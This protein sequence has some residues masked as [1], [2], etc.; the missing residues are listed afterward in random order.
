MLLSPVVT[1]LINPR[2]G[3]VTCRLTLTVRP[4]LVQLS[5]RETVV[6]KDLEGPNIGR[7]KNVLTTPPLWPPAVALKVRVKRVTQQPLTLTQTPAP[8][9]KLHPI[10]QR[11]PS[12]HRRVKA[13]NPYQEQRKYAR[14][15]N[16]QAGDKKQNSSLPGRHQHPKWHHPPEPSSARPPAP[17]GPNSRP[18]RRRPVSRIQSNQNTPPASS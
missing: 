16:K 5:V 15:G 9:N 4:F 6:I 14:K 18:S 17:H 12:R 2:N 8:K 11:E 10:L 7:G 1:D 13:R 3:H